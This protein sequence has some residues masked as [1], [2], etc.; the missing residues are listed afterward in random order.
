MHNYGESDTYMW[1]STGK[2]WDAI[3]EKEQF[4]LALHVNRKSTGKYFLSILITG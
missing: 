3:T 2:N 1:L 4:I